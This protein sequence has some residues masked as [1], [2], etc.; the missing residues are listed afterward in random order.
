LSAKRAA[1]FP[2]RARRNWRAAHPSPSTLEELNAALVALGD[3]ASYRRFPQ[4]VIA[5]LAAGGMPSRQQCPQMGAGATRLETLMSFDYRIRARRLIRG[6]FLIW[7]V[8]L[9]ASLAALQAGGANP[10]ESACLSSVMDAFVKAVTSGRALSVPLVETAEI[11][12]NTKPVAID[13]TVWK[14]VKNVRSTIIVAD[15]STSNVVS[16][17]G[18]ELA[19]GDAA[20]ISTRLKVARGGRIADVEISADRSA[21]VVTSYVWN[22]SSELTSVLPPEQRITRV[23][24]EALARRYFHSLSS[25]VAVQADFD[26]RCNRFH[27]GQQIT[28]NGGNTVEG[29][30]A[31]TCSS[32]LEGNPPWGPATE[33]RFPVIDVERG[34]VLGVTLLHYLS[35]P[36]PQQMYVSE[37]FK[38]V[39]GRIVTIDNIGLMS[40]DATTLGFVH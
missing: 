6:A 7:G 30:P 13:A 36:T 40:Q 21:R 22:L 27:S 3:C 10:C 8:S 20:Y 4:G 5:K 12:E 35:G 25:H 11:R 38:V 24:L 39:N 34:I 17:V 18:V 28:N 23:A 32:S 2:R 16:R 19:G 9:P 15:A 14:D 33:H 1:L 26:P 31:R 29:G 37:L